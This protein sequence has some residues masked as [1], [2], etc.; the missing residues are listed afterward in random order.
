MRHPKSTLSAFA[1]LSLVFAVVTSQ[2]APPVNTGTRSEM[3]HLA[4]NGSDIYRGI[5]LPFTGPRGIEARRPNRNRHAIIF[6]FDQDLSN[7]GSIETTHGSLETWSGVRSQFPDTVAAYIYDV[8]N[9]EFVTITLRD[10]QSTSGETLPL[11]RATVGYL[12]GDVTQNGSVN[13]S[14]IRKAAAS[15]GRN[16]GEGENFVLD[17]TVNNAINVSD[18]RLIGANSG[19]SLPNTAPMITTLSDQATTPGTST[20]A[21]PFAIDDFNT[22]ADALTVTATSDNTSLVPDSN[23]TIMGS[24]ANRTIAVTAAPGQTGTATITVTVSDGVNTTQ[25]SYAVT[26]DDNSPP[27]ALVQV[28]QF[29]GEAPLTLTFDGSASS[30][31]DDNINM[32]IWELGDGTFTAGNVQMTHTYQ[33]PGTYSARLIVVDTEGEFDDIRVE[34][35]VADGSFNVNDTPSEDDASRFLWQAAFGPT[36]ADVASVRGLGFEGWIDE[37]MSLSATVLTQQQF[38]Q[39]A[40][41]NG[42]GQV[43]QQRFAWANNVVEAEDQLRQRVAWALIQILVLNNDQDNSGPIASRTYYNFMVENAFGNYRDLLSDVTFSRPMGEYLTYINNEKENVAAGTVPD[44]NYARE[45]M[46]LFSIGLFELNPDGTRKRDGNGNFI[47]TYTNEDIK[48]FARVFTG[49]QISNIGGNF[50][51]REANPMRLDVGTHEFGQK[52][53][54][55]YPGAVN[56][57]FIPA[58]TPSEANGIADVNFAI[59]NVFNHPNTA[60]FICHQLIQ[61]LVTSNPTPDYVE[62]VAAIF[63]NNGFGVRGDLGA[64]VK[65]ILLDPEA[66]DRTYSANPY[67][68]KIIEPFV[69]KWALYR[70]LDRRDAPTQPIGLRVRQLQF[71]EIDKFGQSY[72]TSPSVFNFFL[73]DF[74]IVNSPLDERGLEA[75]EMQIINEITIF[76]AMNDH[77]SVSIS[78][79]GSEE[80]NVYD[81]LRGLAGNPAQLVDRVDELLMYDTMSSEMRTIL[82][83]AVGQVSGNTNRVRTAIWLTIASPEFQVIN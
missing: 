56:N 67:F 10:I 60:P 38:D 34:I 26:A 41:V 72:M 11:A 7:V 27:E 35:T 61:R 70:V 21:Q 71:G 82:I 44:E 16:P 4:A 22:S 8:P 32:Y 52:Q 13:V 6:S 40:T 73:P 49:L 55:N 48:Q 24:G 45:I 46:Q 65:A 3:R 47:P 80:G 15:S 59:D 66:R 28:D 76:S 31:P 54:L 43:F 36:A 83:N 5:D 78:E 23:I 29:V 57:G 64:V 77:N 53:L 74:T 51:I 18:L 1:A 9:G 25:S 62:R 2:A 33:N 17:V 69:L 81:A 68:G 50:L 63:E 19:D 39:A 20:P 58:R 42:A 75:P 79:N 30:D 12:L 37:Q 14:D